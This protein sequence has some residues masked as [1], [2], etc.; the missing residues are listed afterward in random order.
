MKPISALAVSASLALALLSMDVA[1]CGTCG[2]SLNSDWASQGYE[3]GAGFNLNLRF[4]YI[5]Q[6][7]LRTGRTTVDTGSIGYPTGQEI[8]LRTISRTYLLNLSY[9]PSNNWSINVLVPFT[10][11]THSTIAEGDV[12]PS[13]SRSAGVG[14]VWL[15][16]RYQGFTKDHSFGLQ[17]GVKLPTGRI[18]DTFATGPQ[19][20]QTVDR[21]LQLGSGTTDLLVGAYKF[22]SISPQ[23]GY[24]V[25]GLVQLPMD[26]K[27]GYR[28]GDALNISA[29][30]RYT[31]FTAIT[32]QLQ[33][34]LRAEDRESGINADV[35]NSGA[36]LAYFSPGFTASIGR[37]LELFAFLQIPIYQRVNGYQLEPHY[38][39]SVGLN[40]RF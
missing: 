2:C 7:Q 38:I 36:T 18:D 29:G 22:G 15:V 16:G 10:D 19:A 12:A 32:P 3:F 6:D 5:D 20:G 9:S 37:S 39:L 35:P 1:A 23:W 28:P 8:Q 31:G 34:S 33:L 24:F 40:Y 13:Y 27:D 30:V 11:R 26:S 21:G 25:S 14:D 17:L 4:D